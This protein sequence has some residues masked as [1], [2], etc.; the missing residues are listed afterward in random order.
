MGLFKLLMFC[1]A[2]FI[3]IFMPANAAEGIAKQSGKVLLNGVE[4]CYLKLG[5]GKPIV[6]LHGGPGMFHD[7]FLPHFEPLAQDFQ[8]IFYDQRG[9][10]CSPAKLTADNFTVEQLVDDLEAF[11][12]FLGLPKM[13]LLGHSWGGLLAMHYAIAHP[14]K[15][16]KMIL[17]NP[18]AA[19]SKHHQQMLV[20]KNSR[21][22]P[23]VIA[24]IEQ[25]M[26]SGAIQKGDGVAFKRLVMLA[27]GVNA[28]QPENIE[29][30]LGK[31]KY[32]AQRMQNA[33]LIS[34]LKT[35]F[36]AN[37]DLHLQL[38][39][40]NVQ[41]L[42]IHGDSDAIPL[43]SDEAIV[44]SLPN[45][46]LVRFAKSGHYPYAEQPKRFRSVVKAFINMY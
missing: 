18:A 38:A 5:Q 11:R 13:T 45:A 10:G 29:Q 7:Y 43:A 22:T 35:P 34:Q 16:D 19:D 30:L 21:Y 3:T 42:V 44:K 12:R 9:N 1:S 26:Q 2:M 20:V 15:L 37:Y 27:E 24:E 40:V 14:D 39:K 41:T 17:S 28:H 25:I 33:L 6:V 8:L 36:F 23:Q 31:M 4:H 46:G 32:S